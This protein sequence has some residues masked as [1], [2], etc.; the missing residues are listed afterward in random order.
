MNNQKAKRIVSNRGENYNSKRI[1]NIIEYNVSEI[2][3]TMLV[4]VILNV[5]CVKVDLKILGIEE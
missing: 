1:K 5:K 4:T 3:M 2:Q